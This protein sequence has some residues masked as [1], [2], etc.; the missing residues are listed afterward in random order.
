[1]AGDLSHEHKGSNGRETRGIDSRQLFTYT[2]RHRRLRRVEISVAADVS[3]AIP[4]S[5]SRHG[6]H[7]S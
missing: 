7:Y 4:K 2:K 5:R 3:P 6:C 1:M